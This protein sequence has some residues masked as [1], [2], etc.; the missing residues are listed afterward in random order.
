MVMCVCV[1]VHILFICVYV[2]YIHTH[3][4]IF[5]YT[6]A[7]YVCI[8]FVYTY[9]YIYTH[10]YIYIGLPGGTSGKEPTCQCRRHKRNGSGRS[11]GG[12]H[13]THSSILAWRIPWTEESGGLQSMGSQRVIEATLQASIYICVCVF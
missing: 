1:Y 4:H 11:P 2:C 9:I 12:G 13:T 6:C 8:L 3:T 7:I 5:A 10:T